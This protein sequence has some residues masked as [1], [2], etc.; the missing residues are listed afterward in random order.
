M[1]DDLTKI[2][3]LAMRHE[4]N[5]WNAYYA[6]PDSME[7]AILLGT[8]AMAIIVGYPDRKDA[9]MGLMREAVA[10]IIEERCGTR[11]TFPDGAEPAPEHERS[12]HG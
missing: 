11:P 9:F 1:A 5:Y 2:G 7:G 12:G 10:D 8:I 4:G 6:L 3:R